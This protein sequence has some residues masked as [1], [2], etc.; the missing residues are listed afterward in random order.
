MVKFDVAEA[1]K[2]VLEGDVWQALEAF[3]TE[4]EAAGASQ[5]TVRAYKYGI[6]DFLKFANKHYVKELSID[7]YNRW[8]LERLR[9]GFP[10]G[11][12]DKRRTQA[13]LH[14]YSLYVRSFIKWLGIA[15]KIPAVA[16][17]RGRKNIAT[18]KVEDV[19]KMFETARDILDKTIV[20]LLFETGLRAQELLSLSVEDVNLESR[21]IIVRNAK[22]GDERV[23][24]FGPLSYETLKIYIYLNNKKGGRLFDLTYSG[25][26]KRL[27]TL[28]SRA[29]ID[30][31]RVRPHVL[32]HTFATEALKR[33][34][35]LIALQNILGHK[36]IKTTQIYVHLLK[37]DIRK[38]YENAF[39]H[40]LKS[41]K[42]SHELNLS[43]IVS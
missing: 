13:T 32:R 3:L 7:D 22:F 31:S 18:L 30:P 14:Y 27:K 35:D 38:S 6:K 9:R 36:D 37:E 20:A 12:N 10:E 29:G 33:G 1:T 8:R 15:D 25:L 23:V 40:E 2:E 21:E 34:M 42:A 39:Y 19:K 4:L 28:A 11:S 43:N 17:P 41:W 16:R 24:F 5:K 26:Y